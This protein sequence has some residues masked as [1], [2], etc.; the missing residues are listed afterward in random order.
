MVT[1]L[2]WYFCPGTCVICA[3][4]FGFSGQDRMK[5]FLWNTI[6]AV[7]NKMIFITLLLLEQQNRPKTCSPKMSPFGRKFLIEE[8]TYGDGPL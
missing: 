2:A 1:D 7:K 4:V 3:G 8:I 6:P 5:F